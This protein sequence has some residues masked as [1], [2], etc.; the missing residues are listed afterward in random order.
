MSLYSEDRIF[1][2][3]DRKKKYTWEHEY[4]EIWTKRLFNAQRQAHK[5]RVRL[6]RGFLG[7]D[8]DMYCSNENLS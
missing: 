4:V 6:H 8:L 2:L 1:Y 7:L 5:N 3:A